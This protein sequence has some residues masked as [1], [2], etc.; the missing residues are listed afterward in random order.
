MPTIS[1]IIPAYN[2]GSTILET[3]TSVQQQTFS[4]FEIIVINDGSKDRTLEL[5][6]TVKDPRLKIFSYSNGGVP[7]AR[8]HGL[9]HATGD[10]IAFLDA[11]LAHLKPY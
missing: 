2:A 6:S 10:F 5:L 1:V 4:D 8:N 7:V 3:I 9:E 11:G